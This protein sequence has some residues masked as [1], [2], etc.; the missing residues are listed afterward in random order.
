MF[1][2]F[3]ALGA[4]LYMYD[5]ILIL[6]TCNQMNEPYFTCLIRSAT[7]GAVLKSVTL[8]SPPLAVLT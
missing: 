4:C 5:K 3:K 7:S 8:S 2:N 1:L 6:E